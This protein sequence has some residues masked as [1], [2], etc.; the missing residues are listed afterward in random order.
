MTKKTF[1]AKP[2]L[3]KIIGIF[4]ASGSVLILYTT[5]IGF[6]PE[7]YYEW[8]GYLLS[9]LGIIT[10]YII[11]KIP[12]QKIEIDE[13]GIKIIIGSQVTGFMSKLLNPDTEC[14][15]NWISSV[16]TTR[17]N[18]G[19]LITVLYTSEAVPNQPKDR[20]V[21]DSFTFKDYVTILKIIKERAPHANF[22][23]TTSLILNNQLDIRAV[24]PFFW[25]LAII[26]VLLGLIYD[27][28]IK[29]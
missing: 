2:Y 27:H 21:F 7:P 23:E 3:N 25:W 12:V 11:W 9:S 18:G 28:Y 26:T 5:Y 8:N 13:L 6:I 16:V 4:L 24:R 20:V 1:T 17:S 14:K 15:W 29:G 10:A 19:S 22:D